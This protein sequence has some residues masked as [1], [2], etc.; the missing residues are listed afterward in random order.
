MQTPNKNAP[1]VPAANAPNTRS[2]ARILNNQEESNS[3]GDVSTS[4]SAPHSN[5][6]ALVEKPKE[7][8]PL[9]SNNSTTA[10][11]ADKPPVP[12]TTITDVSSSTTGEG[13]HNSKRINIKFGQNVAAVNKQNP[14]APSE[15]IT[16]PP[17]IVLSNTPPKQ[18][19]VVDLCGESTINSPGNTTQSSIH[20][21]R[22]YSSMQSPVKVPH[23][24]A[25]LAP[26]FPP[27]FSDIISTVQVSGL[28][29]QT[30]SEV[31]ARSLS[32]LTIHSPERELPRY[33]PNKELPPY[34]PE[35]LEDEQIADMTLMK[36]HLTLEAL[37]RLNAAMQSEKP[38]INNPPMS[39]P[40]NISSATAALPPKAPKR[41]RGKRG[42]TKKKSKQYRT[43]AASDV[44]A[45]SYA[46]VRLSW[47]SPALE[48]LKLAGPRI[49]ITINV[50]AQHI[51]YDDIPPDVNKLTPPQHVAIIA[52]LLGSE[53]D[54]LNIPPPVYQ[55]T[56]YLPGVTDVDKWFNILHYDYTYGY[57]SRIL[58]VIAGQSVRFSIFTTPNLLK[59]I[60]ATLQLSQVNPSML[61]Q[62][63]FVRETEQSKVVAGKLEFSNWGIRQVNQIPLEQK[64]SMQQVSYAFKQLTHHYCANVWFESIIDQHNIPK[65]RINFHCSPSTTHQIYNLIHTT[66]LSSKDDPTQVALLN[67]LHQGTK[68]WISTAVNYCNFCIA[69]GHTRVR[70]KHS[71]DQIRCEI[72]R[73]IGHHPEECPTRLN[74]QTHVCLICA[75]RGHWNYRCKRQGVQWR[76]LQLTV[77]STQSKSTSKEAPKRKPPPESVANSPV[78]IRSSKRASTAQSVSSTSG[79][80]T[81]TP[82]QQES[83]LDMRDIPQS[84]DNHP[85]I[86][87]VGMI[88]SSSIGTQQ[89]TGNH[90]IMYDPMFV[91]FV[92]TTNATMLQ[93]QQ[94]N[95]QQMALMLQEL[96]EMRM[97]RSTSFI[98]STNSSMSSSVTPTQE[99]PSRM[100]FSSTEIP[101]TQ[102]ISSSSPMLATT[103]VE[104]GT[105]INTPPNNSITANT[106]MSQPTP[107]NSNIPASAQEWP[108][109]SITSA[110]EKQLAAEALSAKAKGKTRCIH[111]CLK[112]TDP[113]CPIVREG[114]QQMLQ[115]AATKKAH[116]FCNQACPGFKLLIN[117]T[118]HSSR[119]QAKRTH[120]SPVVASATTSPTQPEPTTQE[121][122]A[123]TIADCSSKQS[124][125]A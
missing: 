64:I 117:T 17:V 42:G 28:Q 78:S 7:T 63:S 92:R 97:Q 50:L 12:S 73:T 13:T 11:P 51:K 100:S 55:P 14:T 4:L 39:N 5:N 121:T 82:V 123:N 89:P 72:C 79:T 37:N 19:E 47:D 38:P 20:S 103:E 83:P 54:G 120:P 88:S 80:I 52:R 74:V 15:T 118:S 104:G 48:L 77:K 31:Q 53:N 68:A 61:V 58:K 40:P 69:M 93:L 16:T 112:S 67:V 18:H 65:T 87:S 95:Q 1:P 98:A 33:N 76:E 71:K 94:Q 114:K 110:A 85:L 70:C 26:A 86:P 62:P 102:S 75:G 27:T 21:Y 84:I 23:R 66:Q 36:E 10:L 44:P 122:Q 119:R 32:R 91:E 57:R 106:Q 60:D 8:T 99:F 107:T 96:R 115:H 43:D 125:S 45:S 3:T 46:L 34:S 105:D 35:P 22:D 81:Q 116:P 90:S 49:I 9:K 2:R 25:P 108:I 113:R 59:A 56:Q 101:I 29:V 6:S 24:S 124:P 41:Q 109:H 30:P 111:T